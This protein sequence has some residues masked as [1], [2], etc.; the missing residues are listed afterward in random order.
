[1]RHVKKS[2]CFLLSLGYVELS[3][4][5]MTENALLFTKKAQSTASKVNNSQ[6]IAEINRF[7]LLIKRAV[8]LA[9][10]WYVGSCFHIFPMEDTQ[11]FKTTPNINFW[12]FSKN[13][14]FSL[15]FK[16]LK[17]NLWIGFRRIQLRV[18]VTTFQMEPKHASQWLAYSNQYELWNAVKHFGRFWRK[19]PFETVSHLHL[20]E[21]N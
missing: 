1:M 2:I 19:T 14:F 3:G 9:S 11:I 21:S 15:L 18:G 10:K 12:V 17:F 7:D 6:Y 8:H 4:R 13:I 16:K 5:K 20:I